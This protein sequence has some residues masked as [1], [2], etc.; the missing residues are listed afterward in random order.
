MARAR[1]MGFDVPVY[2]GTGEDF[3]GHRQTVWG[4]RTP[5]LA[6]EYAEMREF[7][8][9][10]PNVQKLLA[11]PG[12]TFDA[13]KLSKTVTINTFFNEMLAQAK[14]RGQELDVS[15]AKELLDVVKKSAKAEE[16]GPNYAR[17]DFWND[18]RS[19]FG[20]EGAK[21]IDDLVDALGFDSFKLQERGSSTLGIRDP[22]NIRSVHAKFDPANRDSADLLA[23]RAAPGAAVPREDRRLTYRDIENQL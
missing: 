21:A 1:E 20:A 6:N 10:T 16:S 22:A 5:E 12:N 3:A 18:A 2:H 19:Y 23:S 13:D 8:G 9:G 17:H 4:S 15:R 7:G 14:R 11:R